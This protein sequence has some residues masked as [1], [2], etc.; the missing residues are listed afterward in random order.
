MIDV[1][2]G[3]T[4]DGTI[5]G[6]GAIPELKVQSHRSGP[7]LLRADLQWQGVALAPRLYRRRGRLKNAIVTLE[8]LNQGKPF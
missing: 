7:Y 6:R 1:Q 2:H 5:A 3:G 8:G 4:L